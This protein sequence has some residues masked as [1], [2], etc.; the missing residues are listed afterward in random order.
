MSWLS[1]DYDDG[2]SKQTSH[3]KLLVL[4]LL[5]FTN[6]YYLQIV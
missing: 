5:L 6:Y 2:V 1:D 4:L 3:N